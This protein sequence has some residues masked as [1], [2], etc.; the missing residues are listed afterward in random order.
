MPQRCSPRAGPPQP[1]FAENPGGQ[2]LVVPRRGLPASRVAAWLSVPGLT[3][4]TVVL[5]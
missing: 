4:P 5:A 3:V 2:M 1:P